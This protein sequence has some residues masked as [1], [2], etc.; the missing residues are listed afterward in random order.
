MTSRAK[1]TIRRIESPL[2]G[3]L[4][5]GVETQVVP[6]YHFA[7]VSLDKRWDKH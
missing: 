1:L 2:E 3:E 6:G 7:V 4:V 5:R